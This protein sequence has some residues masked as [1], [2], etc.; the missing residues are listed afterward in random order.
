VDTSRIGR[1]DAI[2]GGAAVVLVL[3]LFLNWFGSLN[4]W[5]VFSVVDVILLLLAIATIALVGL[6]LAGS[7]PSLPLPAGWLIAGY[8][9]VA[10]ITTFMFLVEG[11]SLGIGIFLA[12]LASAAMTFGGWDATRTPAGAPT[13]SRP[14]SGPA[15]SPRPASPPPAAPDDRPP[16]A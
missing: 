3:S 2:A 13:A 1:G 10:L 8:G 15:T 7:L 14:A 5:Q 4:A 9:A 11:S 16:T 12:L 6:R